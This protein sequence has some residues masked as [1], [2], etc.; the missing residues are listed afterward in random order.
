MS[1]SSVQSI[2]NQW[3]APNAYQA[4]VAKIE[5]DGIQ[6]QIQDRVITAQK[7]FSCLIQP[8]EQDIVSVQLMDTGEFVVTAI[9]ER[10]TAA[11]TQIQFKDDIQVQGQG[12]IDIRSQGN[13]GLMTDQQLFC[14]SDTAMH[15]SNHAWIAFDHTK[16]VM[17]KLESTIDKIQSVS[18][19]VNT[20]AKQAMQRFQTYIRHTE[21]MDQTKAGNKKQQVEGLYRVDTETTLMMSNKD[22]KIDGQHIHM[23]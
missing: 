13:L 10:S 23:G 20:L 18:Q 16:V 15:K 17:S 4:V 2:P 14:S 19:W 11:P 6:I 22:T 7:A 9:L 1:K 12:R 8:V 21:D 5:R 3:A